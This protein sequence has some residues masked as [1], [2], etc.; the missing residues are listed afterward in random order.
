MWTN[1]TNKTPWLDSAIDTAL[2]TTS[3]D[4]YTPTFRTLF[5]VHSAEDAERKQAPL[6]VTF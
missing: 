1:Q 2:F 6:I 3:K 5:A 4:H